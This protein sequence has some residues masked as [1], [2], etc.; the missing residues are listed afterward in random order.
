[1]R[2]SI[3]ILV[4]LVF[5]LAACS[6]N[7]SD[8]APSADSPQQVE[9]PGSGNGDSQPAAWLS[10]PCSLIGDEEMSDLLPN[11]V[12]GSTVTR[13][14]CEYGPVDL[15]LGRVDIEVFVQDVAATGCDLFFS[16]GGF[17][18]AKPVDAIGT[19]ARWK[20]ESGI[21]QLGVCVDGDKTLAVTVYDP[22]KSTDALAVARAVAELAI[23]G[24]G[25]R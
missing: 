25:N 17:N 18:S 8:A 2:P 14:L 23:A 9:A 10:E 15:N 7:G 5:F 13:G 21:K 22:D 12:A 20:G 24:L 1:M 11:P 3:S 16:V 6:D 4:A 19:A